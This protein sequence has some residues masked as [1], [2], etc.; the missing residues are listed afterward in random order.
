MSDTVKYLALAGG[1]G[2]AKLAHGLALAL[3][4]GELLIAVNVGDD[5]R[6]LGLNI[7][8]DLDTVLYT[9]AGLNNADQGWGL[10][11]ET[12][13]MMQA[14][15]RLGGADWFQL[16]DQDLAIHLYRSHALAS[17][18]TLAAITRHLSAKLGVRHKILPVSDDPIATMVHTDQGILAFQDYF[19]RQAC[20]PIT[21]GFSYDGADKA[22]PHPDILAA[23]E[24]ASLRAIFLC[25]SN[26]YLSILPMLAI[27]QLYAALKNRTVPLIAVSPIIGGAALKG[28][29]AKIL[30]EQG[31]SISPQSLI[32][33]YAPLLDAIAVDPQ[34][35]APLTGA[36]I[37]ATN[38]LM[39][40][41]A[42]KKHLAEDLI[43]YASR[44]S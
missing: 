17:G 7:S 26:P 24:S 40:S 12:W 32:D 44:L 4:P 43:R 36:K 20:A 21:T 8:P 35:A 38:I 6:H 11:G 3:P 23:L 14:L 41:I 15:K 16:G 25:P 9:L 33:L 37:L 22:A 34:D 30:Q 31:L 5:F 42:D 27:P 10:Q 13:A 1:V 2:G 29:A 28:P 18:D 19:V 39:R